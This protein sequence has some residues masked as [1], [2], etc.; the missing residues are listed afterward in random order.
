MDIL[1]FILVYIYIYLQHTETDCCDSSVTIF[2]LYYLTLFVSL[3]LLLALLLEG[4]SFNL[5]EF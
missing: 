3:R 5:I 4:K 2:S 1:Y